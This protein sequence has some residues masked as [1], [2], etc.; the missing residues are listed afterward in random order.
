MPHD[1]SPARLRTTRPACVGG[2]K[3]KRPSGSNP[4]P[5][6]FRVVWILRLYSQRY[7]STCAL[8]QVRFRSR[9]CRSRALEPLNQPESLSHLEGKRHSAYLEPISPNGCQ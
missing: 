5:L 1:H 9:G 8:P 2:V 7:Y 6:G 4:R 3:I